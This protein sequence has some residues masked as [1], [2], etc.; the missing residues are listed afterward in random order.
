FLGADAKSP[1][2]LEILDST[3]RV[4]RKYSSDDKAQAPNPSLNVPTYWIR[5]FQPLPATAGMHR[6]IWDLH[7]ATGEGGGRF[8]GEYPISAIYMDTP[9]AQGEWM[10]PGT[11][12]VKL[13][14]DGQSYTQ[15]LLVRPDPRN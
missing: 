12:T 13:T 1:V 11:Y 4:V 8:G 3:G 9:G 15:A 5:P 6:F 7:A 2:T 14:V 10:P